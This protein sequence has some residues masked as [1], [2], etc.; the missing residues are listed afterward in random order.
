MNLGNV[1]EL[2]PEVKTANDALSQY[3]T[4]IQMKGDSMSKAFEQK[5]TKFESDYQAGLLT[6]NQAL[7]LQ[8][9]LQKEDQFLRDYSAA[10]EQQ[11]GQK[12]GELLNPILKRVTDAVS[13]VAK[14]GGYA[15]IFD[16]STGVALYALETEDISSKVKTKLG[17]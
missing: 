14:E 16:T 12:R 2:L 11:I 13:A 3:T 4:A 17:L 7:E 6:A 8:T 1:L 9:T 15:M 10:A 5:V